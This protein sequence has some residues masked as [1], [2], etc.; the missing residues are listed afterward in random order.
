MRQSGEKSRRLASRLCAAL[1]AIGLSE[2]WRSNG[3]H[4]IGLVAIVELVVRP[5]GGKLDA[6]F[7]PTF[8]SLLG[9][10]LGQHS[11]KTGATA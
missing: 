2:K 1:R 4:A 7:G 10:L 3:T 11:R 5:F 9:A 6:P 8:A